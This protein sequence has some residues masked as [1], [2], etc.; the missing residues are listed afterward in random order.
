MTNPEKKPMSF[1]YTFCI[2]DMTYGHLSVM[3]VKSFFLVYIFDLIKTERKKE[4]NNE[5]ELTVMFY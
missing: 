1:Y 3:S 5:I 2:E 4:R